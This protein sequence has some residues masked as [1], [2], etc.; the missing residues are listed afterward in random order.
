MFLFQFNYREFVKFSIFFFLAQDRLYQFYKTA[1][2]SCWLCKKIKQKC[3]K[4]NEKNIWSNKN[5]AVS[6]FIQKPMQEDLVFEQG[7]GKSVALMI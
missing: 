5:D 6:Y 1:Y 3:V 7:F 2:V 4:T